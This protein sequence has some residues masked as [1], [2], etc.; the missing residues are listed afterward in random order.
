MTDVFISHIHEEAELA[1]ALKTFFIAA[2]QLPL[3]PVT[4]KRRLPRIF[5][6]S[7]PEAILPGE[8]WL[9]SIKNELNSAKVMIPLLT[10]R[11]F[12]RYWVNFETGAA[13]MAK[14]RI[15]P[16]WCDE[17]PLQVALPRPYAD[18]QIVQLP[19][20]AQDLL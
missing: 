15:F 3:H 20:R 1:E 10:E 11:S 18:C 6:S 16:A 4:M 5:V 7:E 8:D 19:D 17:Q 14:K 2:I 13:W 12:N 9:V